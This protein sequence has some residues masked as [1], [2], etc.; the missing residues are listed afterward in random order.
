M[1]REALRCGIEDRRSNSLAQQTLWKALHWRS[2]LLSKGELARLQSFPDS[3]QFAGDLTQVRSQIGNAT[4]PLLAEVVG[5]WALQT[6]VGAVHR[7]PLTL[8]R[9]PRE[10]RPQV[11]PHGPV[12]HTYDPLAGEHAAHPGP[13][14][15]PSPVASI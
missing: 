2:R 15:G 1:E 14:L 9:A 10:D 11:E 4:P 6:V 8:A 5:R 13:G 3:W 12:P 7:A